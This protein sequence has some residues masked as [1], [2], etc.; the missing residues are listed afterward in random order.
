MWSP[1]VYIKDPLW[2]IDADPRPRAVRENKD[3]VNV[4]WH[5]D[6]LVQQHPWIFM[7]DLLSPPLDHPARIVQIHRSVADAPKQ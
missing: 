1:G 4:I 6:V 3:C 2:P 7:R 5:D